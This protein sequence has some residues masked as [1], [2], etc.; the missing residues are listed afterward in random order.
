MRWKTKEEK[1]WEVF[2][3]RLKAGAGNDE[4]TSHNMRLVY[5]LSCY[6]WSWRQEYKAVYQISRKTYDILLHKVEELEKQIQIGKED[7][8]A[9]QAVQDAYSW[10]E[11][12]LA[13]RVRLTKAEKPKVY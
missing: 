7:T 6:V 13:H 9:K 4:N 11:S 2:E 8:K 3:K 1:L 10:L 5:T 12:L